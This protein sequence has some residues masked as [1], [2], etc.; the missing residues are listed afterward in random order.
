MTES[1]VM[2]HE[3][4]WVLDDQLAGMSRPGLYTDVDSDFAFLQTKGIDLLVS[5]TLDVPGAS[6]LAEHG[7]ESLHVPVHD[8][9]APT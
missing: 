2:Q 8:F 7:I 3:F 1:K 6:Q 5:L 9:Q 4:S